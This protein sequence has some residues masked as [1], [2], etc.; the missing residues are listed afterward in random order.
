MEI[1]TDDKEVTEKKLQTD[2]PSLMDSFVQT[3]KVEFRNQGEQSGPSSFTD[4]TSVLVQAEQ[5]IQ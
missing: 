4:F 5:E 2:T 1:Q 3:N